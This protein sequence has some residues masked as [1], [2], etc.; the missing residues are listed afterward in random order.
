MKK[1]KVIFILIIL[2]VIFSIIFKG[3]NIIIKKIYV[4]QYS[5]IV[6]KYSQEYDI[7]KYLIY[8]CIKA[9]SNFKEDA[10]SKKDAKGLMQLIDSTASEIAGSIGIEL[11]ENDIF[12]PQININLGTKYLSNLLKKYNSI[13]L[14]LAAYNAGSGNVDNWIKN[15]ILKDDGSNIEDIPYSETKKYVKKILIDYEIYKKI[16]QEE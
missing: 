12:N 11:K 10:V 9:E 7:D 4:T 2:I 5:D 3:K 14:A 13:E 1:I 16:Y 8:A 6:E 15:G